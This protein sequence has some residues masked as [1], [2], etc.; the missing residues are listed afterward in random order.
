MGGMLVIHGG[1]NSDE[2][3]MYNQIEICDLTY[4]KWL[5]GQLKVHVTKSKKQV[6]EVELPNPKDI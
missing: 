2:N 5:I 1:Y 3:Y 4:K 6:E